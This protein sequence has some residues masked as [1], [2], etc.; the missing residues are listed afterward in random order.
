[1]VSYRFKIALLTLPA[2]TPSAALGTTSDCWQVAGTV[3]A[4]ST[5]RGPDHVTLEGT[6]SA[7][8]SAFRFDPSDRNFIG[9]IRRVAAIAVYDAMSPY[10]ELI[11]VRYDRLAVRLASLTSA[12]YFDGAHRLTW[13]FMQKNGANGH[14]L[15]T[16]KETHALLDRLDAVEEQFAD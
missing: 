12:D 2:L 11:Q 8:L 10:H 5:P 15:P 1:M 16:L 6:Y 14:Q 9:N 3:D 7:D 4:T 13:T